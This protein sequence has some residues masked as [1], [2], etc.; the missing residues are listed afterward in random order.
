MAIN[1]R[2]KYL[3]VVASLSAICV[4]TIS[5]L[6]FA[7]PPKFAANYSFIAE[8]DFGSSI[9]DYWQNILLFIPFGTSLA[10]IAR[11]G[12]RSYLYIIIACTVACAI[13][14]TA[15]ESMQI[16]LTSRVSNLSDII[17]NSLGGCLGASL[18]CWRKEAIALVIGLLTFDRRKLGVNSLLVAIFSYCV[19]VSIAVLLLLVNVNLSNWDDDFYLVLGNEVS[20]D[21]PWNGYL[22]RLYICDRALDS[23]QI[24]EAF[25]SSEQSDAFFTRLPSLVTSIKSSPEQNANVVKRRISSDLAWR[26]NP[27]HLHGNQQIKLPKQET[28]SG[29]ALNRDRWLE[30][31]RPA[32]YLI[33][34]L[35]ESQEFS[36]FLNVA[37]KEINQTGPARIISISNGVYAHNLL[38]GQNESDL[39]FRLRTPITGNLSTQPEFTIP[40]VFNSKTYSKILI[41]FGQ[42]KLSF[43][44]KNYHTKYTFE[45]TPA[46]SF[47]SY[48]PWNIRNWT[49][50]LA[51]Y[52]LIKYQIWFYTIIILPLIILIAILIYYLR[53]PRAEK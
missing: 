53:S 3:F 39:H 28:N 2:F 51:S 19:V 1:K 5:P 36:L 49:F 14:S 31:D 42:K 7:I 18:Y 45:F 17:C 35:K 23:A 30:S 22:N 10:A 12:G 25:K 27:R 46:I 13:A 29:I 26:T 15:I 48:I 4:A 11:N 44:L 40:N 34:R 8:F 41:T 38:L 6:N 21:R 9:K 33:R 50:D 16:F 52:K 37:A 20:G 47:V 43:Y 24:V 32:T